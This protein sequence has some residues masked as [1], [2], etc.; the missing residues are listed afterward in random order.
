MSNETALTTTGPKAIAVAPRLL[1]LA[2]QVD[3]IAGGALEIFKGADGSF[4]LEIK[5]AAAMGALRAALTP[6][7]M[8]PVMALMNTD[9][10][11][12]CDRPNKDNPKPYPVEVIRDVLIEAKIRGFRTLGN[13]F[14]VISGR[15]YAAKA[16]LWRKVTEYPGVTDYKDGFSV[17]YVQ[18]GRTL[19]K[20]HAA[21]KKDGIPDSLD[22]EI[23]I[24][25]NGNMG[26]DAVVGKAERKLLARVLR[27]VSGIV[28]P[29]GDAE[30]TAPEPMR[31]PPPPSAPASAPA[32]T[33]GS[34]RATVSHAERS[35]PPPDL[36]S[37]APPAAAAKGDVAPPESPIDDILDR[38]VAAALAVTEHGKDEARRRL[39]AIMPEIP[40]LE[41]AGK[42]SHAEREGAKA[43]YRVARDII[44]RGLDADGAAAE[45]A[46]FE[47]QRNAGGVS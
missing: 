18:G 47:A 24:R 14:N 33:N 15:F 26:A 31:A 44:E 27:R 29:E 34:A 35:A 22:V 36:A 12:R 16:G 37:D 39:D 6:E 11:F 23:E 42:I 30:E 1:E 5:M 25:V 21:W 8:E 28:T 4:A 13:E 32:P 41:R 10:G 9:L 38:I 20:C 43:Y 46:K 40:P 17:P 3:E 45:I 7:V 19:V 2:T